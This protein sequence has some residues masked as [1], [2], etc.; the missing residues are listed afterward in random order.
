VA[1][2]YL[3]LLVIESE[4]EKIDPKHPVKGLEHPKIN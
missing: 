4:K 1:C 3:I 2:G